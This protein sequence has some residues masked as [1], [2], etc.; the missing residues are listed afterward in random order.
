M[1]L[2]IDP[3]T[4]SMLFTILIGLLGTVLYFLRDAKVRLRFLFSGGKKTENAD[5]RV[6]FAIFTASDIGIFLS[7][8]VIN[9]SSAV[10]PCCI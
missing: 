1:R 2:Y 5:S 9:L 8:S 4:G 7:R 3:G 10:F 6:P